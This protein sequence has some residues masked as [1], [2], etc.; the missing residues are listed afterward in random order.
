MRAAYGIKSLTAGGHQG[1]FSRLFTHMTT[2][3]DATPIAVSAASTKV[4][5]TAA[6]IGWGY[7]SQAAQDGRISNN[8]EVDFLS[9]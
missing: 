6:I 2:P 9:R 8:K 3:A 4:G 5:V 1:H 7:S